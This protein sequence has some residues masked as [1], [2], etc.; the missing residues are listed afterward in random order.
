MNTKL[1]ILFIIC[2]MFAVSN[3]AMAN[4]DSRSAKEMIL[5]K[6]LNIFTKGE[7]FHYPIPEGAVIECYAKRVD[8]SIDGFLE[9]NEYFVMKNGSLY[10]NTMNKL[11]KQNDNLKKIDRVKVSKNGETLL[12]YDP[13][14]EPTMRRHQRN[15]KINLKTGEYYM[16][17]TQDN[18]MWYRNITTTGVCRVM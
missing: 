14:W 4:S 15:I 13:L 2:F 11:Y 6:N 1:R 18:W 10:S 9:Y 5:A 7:P 3:I 12:L 16:K 17:G 8:G